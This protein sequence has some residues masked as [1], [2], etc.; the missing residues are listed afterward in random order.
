MAQV[1]G[2]VIDVKDLVL[3]NTIADEFDTVAFFTGKR[4]L[5]S[6]KRDVTIAC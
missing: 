5:D 2:C 3:V 6:V 1:V 4:G